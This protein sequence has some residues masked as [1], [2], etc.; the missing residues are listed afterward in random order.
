MSAFQ[1]NVNNHRSFI[2]TSKNIKHF[3]FCFDVRMK[4]IT[5]E[6]INTEIH[7]HSIIKNQNFSAMKEIILMTVTI[8]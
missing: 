5:C 2:I 6:N 4:L 8:Y 3:V 1:E 7:T